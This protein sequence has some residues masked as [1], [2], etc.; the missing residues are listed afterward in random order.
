MVMRTTIAIQ[1]GAEDAPVEIRRNSAQQISTNAKAGAEG[2]TWSQGRSA[3]AYELAQ[4]GGPCHK[5]TITRSTDVEA[6]DSPNESSN[7]HSPIS[8]SA[9]LMIA[10]ML[11]A[12]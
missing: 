9:V 5:I 12:V 3:S 7:I 11:S 8:I 2:L 6:A 1:A 4:P 10:A